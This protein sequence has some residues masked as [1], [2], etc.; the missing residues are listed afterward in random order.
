VLTPEAIATRLGRGGSHGLTEADFAQ[1]IDGKPDVVLLGT[2]RRCASRSAPDARARRRG[3][4][5]EVMDTAAACRTY[6]IL[7]AEGAR[8]AAAADRSADSPAP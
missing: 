3:D 4:R 8:C 6:N 7:A 2:G 1:L 5:L